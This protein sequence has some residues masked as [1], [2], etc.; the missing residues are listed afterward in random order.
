MSQE[1]TEDDFA[2]VRQAR[3]DGA[4]I[5]ELAKR[6]R[7]SPTTILEALA[8][9]RLLPRLRELSIS[10]NPEVTRP[11]GLRARF[12]PRLRLWAP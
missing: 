10:R 5:R 3:R 1:V 6:F 8:D 2:Q 11:E 4:S 7:H 12:G 9:P